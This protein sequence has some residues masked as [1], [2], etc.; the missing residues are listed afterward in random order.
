[1]LYSEDTSPSKQHAGT[2]VVWVPEPGA[3]TVKVDVQDWWNTGGLVV[4]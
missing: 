1:M 4:P 2:Y 3:T